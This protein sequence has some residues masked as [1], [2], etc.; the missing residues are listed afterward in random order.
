MSVAPLKIYAGNSI[1]V[2]IKEWMKKLYIGFSKEE[3]GAVRNRFNI[4]MDHFQK[5]EEA[6]G[7]IK[8]HLRSS[9]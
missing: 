4:E 3:V 5:V 8:D 9:K 7:I 1:F 2:E 6:L